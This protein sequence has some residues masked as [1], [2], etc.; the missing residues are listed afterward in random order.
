MLKT[1][2]VLE[3]T[4]FTHPISYANLMA[5]SR[6]VQEN[7][8]DLLEEKYSKKTK[9]A[10][11]Y[12]ERLLKNYLL[13]KKVDLES[14]TPCELDKQLQGFYSSVRKVD[15]GQYTVT[16]FIN[17]RYAI[18]RFLKD[19]SKVDI[20]KDALFTPSND[21]HTCKIAQLKKMGKGTVKHFD[22]SECTSSFNNLYD[23]YFLFSSPSYLLTWRR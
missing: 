15:K 3:V 12:G 19:N 23:V 7:I 11:Q 16:S 22:V 21:I 1:I 6:F 13:E 2:G 9:E 5:S 4:A 14:L 17:L 10:T 18:C 8:E 20:L